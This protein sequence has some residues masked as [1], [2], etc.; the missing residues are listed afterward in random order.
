MSLALALLLA[1]GCLPKESLTRR[2]EVGADVYDV[3]VRVEVSTEGIEVRPLTWELHGKVGWS[4]TRTFRDGSLG[5]LVEFIGVTAGIAGTGGA[6]VLQGA[7][8]ELRSFPD[9][10]LL[11]VAGATPFMGDGAHLELLD[12]LWFA[13]SPHIPGPRSVSPFPSTWPTWT[14]EG[15]RSHAGLTATW[16]SESEERWAYRGKTERTG[17]FV[18]GTSDVSGEMTGG[19]EARVVRHDWRADGTLNTIWPASTVQQRLAITLA[20]QHAG[21]GPSPA[22]DMPALGGDAASDA[23][24]L[25]LKDGRAAKDVEVDVAVKTP[26]L[27]LP[28]DLP[29]TERAAIRARL[30]DAGSIRP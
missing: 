17:G 14:F 1:E 5:H 23:R 12:C 9:G 20:V 16:S 29:T 26:F 6:D 21:R 22:L 15:M 7:I 27:F 4:Y 13:L 30:F 19:A 8:V 2:D 18:T 3:D 25:T 28:D 24:P 11:K 10:R